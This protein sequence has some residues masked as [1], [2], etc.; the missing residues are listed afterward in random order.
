MNNFLIIPDSFKGTLSA[1]EVC[2]AIKDGI[3]RVLPQASVRKI[4]AA[5]GGEGT[6][7]ALLTALGG[8]KIALTVSDP[9]G[10]EIEGS[11]GILPNGT[12]VIEMA[13][14]A[15]LPLLSESE[16]NPGI[17]TTYGVGQLL[18][19]AICRGCKNILMGLGGSSTNDFGCGAAVAMGALFFDADG[20]EFLPTGGTLH[21]IADYDLTALSEKLT[22]CSVTV[23]CD[24]DNP[25]YGTTGAAYVFAPQKGADADCVKRLDQ[26]LR[27]FG[28]VIRQKEQIDVQQ[29][30][31]GGAAGAMGAGMAVLFGAT[32]TSGIDAVLDAVKFEEIAVGYDC[33]FTGEG[34]FD[35]QSLGGKVCIGLAK[36]A[37]PLGIPV[38]VI[39]GGVGDDIDAAY[40]MGVSAVFSINRLPLPLAQSAPYSKDNLTF[41]TEQIVRTMA[42][43]LNYWR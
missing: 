32:L 20:N 13:A 19:D 24:I 28:E 39:A 29:I 22:G 23:I 26:N 10:R 36:R 2:D 34:K 37:K 41:V 25:T 4:P 3:C 17:T 18:D 8:E 31:G 12:A 9:L 14:A 43:K 16:R 21:R 33:I 27:A 11:Y 38:I 7:D 15:G 6:V 40:G 5:D 1:S 30:K 35:S 42:I